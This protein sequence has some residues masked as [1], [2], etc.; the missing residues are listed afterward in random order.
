MLRR[1]VV[2]L[3]SLSLLAVMAAAQSPE[4]AAPRFDPAEVVSTAELF[5]PPM[6]V[7]FGTVVLEVT[8]DE[9]GAIEKVKVIRDIK[10]LT[11]EAEKCLRKWSFRPARLNGRPVRSIIPVAFTFNNPYTGPPR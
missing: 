11:P 3:G 10:S 9:S 8:L 5:Y 7:G 4:K 1:L 2:L 6:S